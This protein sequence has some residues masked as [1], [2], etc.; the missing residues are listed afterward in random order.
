MP[1][2][3][4]VVLLEKCAGIMKEYD[5]LYRKT[6]EKYNIFQIAHISE[7]EVIMC[8]VIADLLNPKGKHYKGDLYLKLFW[9]IVSPKIKNPPALDTSKA[10]VKTEYGTDEQR[11]IDIAIEEG[12]VFIP[13]E[14][15]IRAGEQPEQIND[16]AEYAAKRNWGRNIPVLYL[17]LEGGKSWTA[18][19]HEYVRISFRN[20]ILTWLSRCLEQSETKDTPPVCEVIKQLMSAIKSILGYSEDDKMNNEIETQIFQS[21]ETIKAALEIQSVLSSIGKK[22]NATRNLFTG[23]ILDKVQKQFPNAKE[24][25]GDTFYAIE[26][27]VKIKQ[28]L[29][30]LYVYCD[31]DGIDIA[32]ASG[33]KCP[34]SVAEAINNTMRAW[35]GNW[36]ADNTLWTAAGTRYPGLENAEPELYQYLLYN[37]YKQNPQEAA[38]LI[39]QM[40]EELEKC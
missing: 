27:P 22:E 19:G 26:V 11:R 37:E 1:N 10:N 21:P 40:V 32:L 16:Y 33:K 20:D 24:W 28:D 34:P 18:G 3:N 7:K 31:W 6:G 9:D 2:D 30:K 35:G 13:I 5:E 25:N 29:C 12:T 14:V 39:I 36:A 17:T 15:K 23:E 38:K 4:V 8:R